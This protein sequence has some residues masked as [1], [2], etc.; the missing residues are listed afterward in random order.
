LTCDLED[1]CLVHEV[2]LNKVSRLL[3][4]AIFDVV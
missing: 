2:D 3:L 1:G 4:V